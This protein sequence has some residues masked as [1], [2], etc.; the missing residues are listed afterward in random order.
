MCPRISKEPSMAE[1]KQ[2]CGKVE[3]DNITTVK[4]L[5]PEDLVG[6]CKDLGFYFE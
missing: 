6:H 4:R 1:A 2:T 3:D 5:N